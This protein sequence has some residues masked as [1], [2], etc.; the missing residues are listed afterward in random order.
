MHLTPG[1]DIGEADS[2]VAEQ[3][4][5]SDALGHASAIKPLQGDHTRRTFL[6]ESK[7]TI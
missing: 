6:V 2:A 5:K 7:H 4:T 3:G 1:S